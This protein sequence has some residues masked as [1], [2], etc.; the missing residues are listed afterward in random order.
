MKPL[1]D[2]AYQLMLPWSPANAYLIRG[3]RGLI[4]IDPGVTWNLNAIARQLKANGLSPYQVT[5]ILLTHYDVDHALS[6]HTWAERTGA[7][8]WIGA[9]DAAILRHEAPVPPTPF[10]R[11]LS[12]LPIPLPDN[13][14]LLVGE[15]EIL[16]GIRAV[17]TPGH[18]PGHYAFVQ[19]SVGFIG[20]LGQLGP[21]GEVLPNPEFIDGDL[22]RAAITREQV[23][24]LGVRTLAAGH[25]GPVVRS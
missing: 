13:A 19:G 18:T 7:T 8:V 15:T 14:Q 1:G 3:R 12:P 10:R 2:N 23:A 11:F 6:A 4:L 24:T 5:D 25:S 16:D 20:D 9:P 22:E 17:P 21:H